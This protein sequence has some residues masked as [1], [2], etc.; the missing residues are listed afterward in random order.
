M[1]YGPTNI[2][3]VSLSEVL[4][5]KSWIKQQ[6]TCGFFIGLLRPSKQKLE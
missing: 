3:H 1:I 4:D 6:E 2:K 5:W